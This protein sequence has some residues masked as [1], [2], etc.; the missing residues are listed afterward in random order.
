M[1]PSHLADDEG[2]IARLASLLLVALLAAPA[3]GESDAGLCQN[4]THTFEYLKTYYGPWTNFLHIASDVPL[5][6]NWTFACESAVYP[7]G[8]FLPVS[9]GS[10]EGVLLS[11]IAFPGQVSTLR[12]S[13]YLVNQT[14]PLKRLYFYQYLTLR[15]GVA[16]GEFGPQAHCFQQVGDDRYDPS[17]FHNPGFVFT[18]NAAIDVYVSRLDPSFGT[19]GR[20]QKGEIFQWAAPNPATGFPEYAQS[21]LHQFN[22]TTGLHQFTLFCD[23][24]FAGT[25]PHSIVEPQ[26]ETLQQQQQGS[27]T[28]TGHGHHQRSA[29][30]VPSWRDEPLVEMGKWDI[31]ASAL[32]RAK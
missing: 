19:L 27:S 13:L 22:D 26:P 24:A 28:T 10:I 15:A 23:Y 12:H 4:T 29:K 17:I 14:D 8:R 21:Y 5:V 32:K 20:M 7:D 30:G 31:P 3:R 25:S 16:N 18:R 11:Y 6:S 9:A 1:P 2:M